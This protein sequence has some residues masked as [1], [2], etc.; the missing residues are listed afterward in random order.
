[1]FKP[2]LG[3]GDRV[4]RIVLGVLLVAMVFVGPKIIFGWLGVYLVATGALGICPIANFLKIDTRP[5]KHLT[6]GF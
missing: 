4:I 2:N 6:G 1:M 3:L 5:P